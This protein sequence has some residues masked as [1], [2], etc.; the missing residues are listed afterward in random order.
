[1][2]LTVRQAAQLL[3]VPEEVVHKWIRDRGLPATRY[4][5]QYWLNKVALAEWAQANRVALLP[6]PPPKH[7]QP[8]PT[9]AEALAAG[10][11]HRG[12]K[13]KAKREVLRAVVSLLRLPEG[14]DREFVFQ[15]LMAREDQGS[16]GL[17]DGIAI[18]HVR[19]PIVMHLEKP[20]VTL[21]Y[22]DEP[23]DFGA[24]DGKPVFALFTMVNPTIRIHLHLF[25]RLAFALKSAG[26]LRRVKERAS[27]EQVIA[28]ARAIE[29]AMAPPASGAPPSRPGSTRGKTRTAAAAAAGRD[30][31]ATDR[32]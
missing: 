14:T 17:G 8:F 29:A 19:N 9:L 11:V 12:V 25:S 4:N 2:R 21:C 5:E 3:Q 7:L 24:I 22:L 27:E 18:P 1:M 32:P 15:M 28:E 30:H 26:F 13:G 16:T 20:T 10:G 6:E 31:P 23:I